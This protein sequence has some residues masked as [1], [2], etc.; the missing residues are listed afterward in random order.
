MHLQTP[1]E[2][3]DKAAK[4]AIRSIRNQEFEKFLAVADPKN[5][6]PFFAK[7]SQM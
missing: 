2:V 4:A 5:G 3:M 1:W 6:E 7:V